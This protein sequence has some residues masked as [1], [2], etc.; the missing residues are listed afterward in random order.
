MHRTVAK[1]SS[2]K[3]QS[4]KATANANMA[5]DPAAF[6]ALPT[7]FCFNQEARTAIVA[8]GITVTQNLIGITHKDVDNIAKIIHA[9]CT[10]PMIVPYIAQKK[11]TMLAFWVNPCHRNKCHTKQVCQHD[12]G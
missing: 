11:L 3:I 10:Q 4:K 1:Q 8:N 6:Q 2:K 7:R 12:M 9:N 5:A